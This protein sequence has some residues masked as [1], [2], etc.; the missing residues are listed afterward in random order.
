MR[1]KILSK[2][3]KG[4]E[5]SDGLNVGKRAVL[6]KERVKMWLDSSG[7][8]WWLAAGF[9]KHGSCPLVFLQSGVVLG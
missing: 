4:G 3:L 2:N 8:G 7:A 5:A 6:N 9:N 1:T